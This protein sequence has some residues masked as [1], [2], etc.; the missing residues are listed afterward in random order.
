MVNY[1]NPG[2]WHVHCRCK[3]F[4]SF[5]SFYINTFNQLLIIKDYE[6]KLRHIIAH[7]VVTQPLIRSFTVLST[8]GFQRI[9][10]AHVTCWG[11]CESSHSHE[12]SEYNGKHMENNVQAG[13]VL[14]SSLSATSALQCG[15]T[16]PPH[17]IYVIYQYKQL[18]RLGVY[19]QIAIEWY[20]P[21]HL[22][23]L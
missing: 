22:W 12:T 4:P 8:F 10:T 2:A 9:Y 21:R 20:L 23:Q 7:V 13:T 15:L 3:T 16:V 11:Q 18:Y 5:P 19:D 17:F 6:N 14:N 1:S